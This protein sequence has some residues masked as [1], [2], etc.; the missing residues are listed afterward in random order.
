MYQ[1]QSELPNKDFSPV[2][3]TRDFLSQQVTKKAS[4]TV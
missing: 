2:V 3:I 4:W 1:R